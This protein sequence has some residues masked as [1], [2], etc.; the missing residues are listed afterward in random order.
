MAWSLQNGSFKKEC[1]M[2]D[3]SSRKIY[4][5]LP[6]H[7]NP[8]FLEDGERIYFEMR[9]KYPKNNDIDL[10]NILNGLCASIH[11]LMTNNVQKDNYKQFLQLVYKILIKNT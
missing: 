3:G 1:E 11:C 10:D 2:N 6:A 4:Q 9:K 5:D 8:H 7:E